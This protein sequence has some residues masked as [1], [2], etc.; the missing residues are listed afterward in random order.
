LQELSDTY[1]GVTYDTLR[2]SFGG[3]CVLQLHPGEIKFNNGPLNQSEELDLVM[4][5]TLEQRA[6]PELPDIAGLRETYSSSPAFQSVVSV[7][8]ECYI[9]RHLVKVVTPDLPPSE[10]QLLL[11]MKCEI[12]QLPSW[13]PTTQKQYTE[14]FVNHRTHVMLSLALGG[15]LRI[16]VDSTDRVAK[17]MANR[18]KGNTGSGHSTSMWSITIF[19]DGGASIAAEI[20]CTLQ[21]Q[22]RK[23]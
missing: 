20:T 1:L 4:A 7:K 14:F 21:Y 15:V 16:I 13:S 23:F 6:R 22:F 3:T 11:D 5:E 2:C 8:L 9:F 18:D 10:L 17:V 12:E 19:C